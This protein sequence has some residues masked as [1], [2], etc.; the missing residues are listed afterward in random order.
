MGS[1]HV[2]KSTTGL[3]RLVKKT[4]SYGRLVYLYDLLRE[5]VVRDIKMRYKRSALGMAWSL[6][7]PLSHMLVFTFLSRRVLS[8]DIANYPAFVFIGTLAWSW[9]TGTVVAATGAITGGRELVRRPG[10]PVAILPVAMVTTNLIHFL[11]ALII[12]VLFFLVRGGRLTGV[13]LT[14][15]LVIMPQ[16]LLILG[17]SYLAATFQVTFR[18]TQHILGVLFR[19]LY[20]L[21]PIFYEASMVPPRYEALYRLNPVFHLIV[22]YRVIL[23]DGTLPDFRALLAVGALSGALLWIGHAVFKQASYRFVEEL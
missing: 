7:D 18:D 17:L 8:L 6:L 14:L 21:T 20:F 9:F 15:P 23:M 13:I 12:P 11:L 5:L 22:A 19:L 10:F 3:R 1:G 16:F 4:W 2:G